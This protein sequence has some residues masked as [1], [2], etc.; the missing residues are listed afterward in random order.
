MW[1]TYLLGQNKDMRIWRKNVD[2][3]ETV[4]EILLIHMNLLSK[5]PVKVISIQGA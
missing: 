5:I 3:T 2:E 4:Y 1:E